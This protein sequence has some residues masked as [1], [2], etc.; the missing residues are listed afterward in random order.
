MTYAPINIQAYVSAYA[1]AVAGMAVNGWIVDP[2]SDNY[3][4]V[5]AI[6]GAF[7]EAFDQAWNN[8]A[9]LNNLELRAIQAVCQNEF[10]GRGPGS[11]DN[12]DFVLSTTWTVPAIACVALILASDAYF[13]SQGID[14]GTPTPPPPPVSA[15]AIVLTSEVV[16]AW[17]GFPTLIGADDTYVPLSQFIDGI[18]E[19]NPF[20][21]TSVNPFMS[22]GNGANAF[23]FGVG[24]SPGVLVIDVDLALEVTFSAGAGQC[25]LTPNLF[26]DLGTQL[27]F[28]GGIF[29]GPTTQLVRYHLAVT[30]DLGQSRSLALRFK[31]NDQGGTVISGVNLLGCSTA[32]SLAPAP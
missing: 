28:S 24:T 15:P 4:Q 23:L 30:V 16:P 1:G 12:P 20:L 21:V 19:R 26:D 7:S 27:T 9:D 25:I 31:K 18:N 6:A 11:L 8:A 29:T 14:P 10:T 5:S 22:G 2:T 32:V 17:A 13:A 3:A